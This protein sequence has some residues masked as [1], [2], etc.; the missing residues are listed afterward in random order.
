MASALPCKN[1]C[2]FQ[3]PAFTQRLIFNKCAAASV[4]PCSAGSRVECVWSFNERIIMEIAHLFKL[5]NT[6]RISLNW[7]NLLGKLI[8]CLSLSLFCCFQYAHNRSSWTETL[9][10]KSIRNNDM[11]YDRQLW[12]HPVRNPHCTNTR[13]NSKETTKRFLAIHSGNGTDF[14]FSHLFYL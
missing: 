8:Q 9:Q 7:N 5:Y 6:T 12:T 11:R 10:F 3:L 2:R 14:Y 13:I 4:V 1:G